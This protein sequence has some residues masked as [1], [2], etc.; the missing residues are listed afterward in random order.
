MPLIARIRE[1]A[2]A[3]GKV[4]GVHGS[5]AD[6]AIRMISEGFNLVTPTSDM[7]LVAAGAAQ[8]VADI[9]AG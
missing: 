7:R 4:A 1:A 8:M 9:K 6:Y 3:A 5:R 2:H